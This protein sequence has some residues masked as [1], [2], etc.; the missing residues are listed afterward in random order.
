MELHARAVEQLYDSRLVASVC[1]AHVPRLIAALRVSR[2]E[3]ERLRE[4]AD[5][6]RLLG[7]ARMVLDRAAVDGG[8][9]VREECADMAQRIVDLIGHPVTDE[10]PHA[11]VERDEL[12]AEV[13]RLRAELANAHD[14]NGALNRNLVSAGAELER[15]AAERDEWRDAHQSEVGS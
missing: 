14:L 9:D 3:V 12:R 10:P 8:D 13:E 2:A 5:F 15:L 7:P 6:A 1:A 11:L 4:L